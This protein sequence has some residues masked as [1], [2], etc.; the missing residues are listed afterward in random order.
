MSDTV[1]KIKTGGSKM[2]P[3]AMYSFAVV[4]VAAAIFVACTSAA[5]AQTVQASNQ[6]G[7]IPVNPRALSATTTILNPGVVS[8]VHFG[9]LNITTGDQQNYADF[10]MLIVVRAPFYQNL[11]PRCYSFYF[12][13]FFLKKTF[14]I[15]P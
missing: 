4:L 11:L 8:W 5:T 14:I 15:A 2:K 9:D 10:K 3:K 1:P 13:R 12:L 7:P 6:S